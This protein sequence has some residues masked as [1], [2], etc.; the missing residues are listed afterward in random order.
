LGDTG[1]WGTDWPSPGVR[2]LRANLD[3]FLSLRLPEEWKQGVT[4]ANSLQLFPDGE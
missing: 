2:D 3:Q 1:L 4:V